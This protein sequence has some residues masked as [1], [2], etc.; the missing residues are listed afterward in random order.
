M[1]HCPV[2]ATRAD[3]WAVSLCSTGNFPCYCKN[4]VMFFGTLGTPP[5]K[6]STVWWESLVFFE[7]EDMIKGFLKSM[8]LA[9][10]LDYL[11]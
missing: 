4:S 3:S 6:N 9:L 10:S 11:S 2:P 8:R 1:V 5:N 7:D